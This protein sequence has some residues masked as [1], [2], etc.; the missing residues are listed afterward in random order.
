VSVERSVPRLW[1]IDEATGDRWQA[2]PAPDPIPSGAVSETRSYLLALESVGL[3]REE[4]AELH[5]DDRR[6]EALRPRPGM[7]GLWR[8]NPGFHAGSL[9]IRVTLPGRAAID[10]ELEVDPDRRKLVRADFDR[11]LLDI[12]EDT[13]ALFSLSAFR[14]P[15]GRDA[16][17][18]RPP[19]ARLELIRER[20]GRLERVTAAIAASPMR[21][22]H[23][24]AQALPV[25]LAH[26]ARSEEIV[27]SFR[28]GRV[29]PVAGAVKLPEG[30]RGMLPAVIRTRRT[31][32]TLDTDE[33][34]RMAACLRSWRTWLSAV[35]ELLGA[36]AAKQGSSGARDELAIWARRCRQLAARVS[37]MLRLAPFASASSGAEPRLQMNSVF[38]RVPAYREFFGIWRDLNLGLAEVFGDF[39]DMPLARTHELYELWCFLRLVRAAALEFPGE[40]IDATSLFEKLGRSGVEVA[41]GQ[42][43]IAFGDGWALCF[44][45]EYREF[46]FASDGCGS[47]SRTMVPDVVL[48]R[49]RADGGHAT[50]IVLDAKYRIDAAL[51]DALSSIHSYRDALVQESEGGLD[52]VVH[53]AYLMAPAIGVEAGSEDYRTTAMPARLFLPA[54][55][56]AFRF[57][58]IRLVPGCDLNEVRSVLRTVISDA[59]GQP[60]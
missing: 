32:G 3:P 45:R 28:S 23:G 39:V 16:T 19:L 5:I 51:G 21:R 37:A 18:R 27:A 33:H 48:H 9:R 49:Q 20:I 41:A 26:R 55:R 42:A 7:S 52:G 22:L 29:V 13:S 58:A 38:R 60:A 15:I 43:R 36:D 14:T 40:G 10:F 46:W 6:Q 11:M 30:L 25:H 54:Y 59:T 2:W 12:L 1:L 8:W 17:G 34:R 53:A 24:E 50:L 56:D 4:A 57:G 35:A 47:F 31:T 44:Q